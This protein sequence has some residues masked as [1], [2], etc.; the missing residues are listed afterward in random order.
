M[1]PE[2]S[3]NFISLKAAKVTVR[4]EK[5]QIKKQKPTPVSDTGQRKR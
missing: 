5:Y 2:Q 4:L 1:T 3:N